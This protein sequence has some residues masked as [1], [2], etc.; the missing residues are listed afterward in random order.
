MRVIDIINEAEYGYTLVF[1]NTE[2]WIDRIKQF[3]NPNDPQRPF[4]LRKDDTDPA[5]ELTADKYDANERNEQQIVLDEYEKIK[6]AYEAADQL[7]MSQA[8]KDLNVKL[9][10]YSLREITRIRREMNVPKIK[11]KDRVSLADQIANVIDFINS[12][13]DRQLDNRFNYR[14]SFMTDADKETL[15]NWINNSYQSDTKKLQALVN[16]LTSKE[17]RTA[18][19]KELEHTHGDLPEDFD[20]QN[21]LHVYWQQIV[22]GARLRG[23]KEKTGKKEYTMSYKELWQIIQEQ[24]WKCYL[25]N[26]PM[27]GIN[28]HD[29]SIS[30]DR[31]D[32]T[33][34]YIPGNV[35]FCCYR[36]NIIK[37]TLAVNELVALCKQILIHKNI[38]SKEL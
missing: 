34:G 29:N 16:W 17:S 8:T 33:V 1:D 19:P 24:E 12:T 32:S 5:Y 11:K 15:K 27:L 30:I 23:Y 7:A 37:G 14:R 26:I 6:A 4:V 31:K 3:I 28:S 21:P 13:D 36:A 18:A 35:A 25:T 10:Q 2:S 20:P 9:K 22:D 38:I